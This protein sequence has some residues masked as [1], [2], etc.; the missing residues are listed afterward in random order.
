[1]GIYA[2]LHVHTT[3]SDGQLTL[4]ELPDVAAE[5]ELSVVGVTD[6]DRLHP[7][8]DGPV[9][10]RDGVT[11]VR[12]IELRVQA[13]SQ[14]V[15]LLGYGVEQTDPLQTR[16]EALQQNRI[17]RTR[18]ILERVE[19]R[20]EIRLDVALT[21]GV[22]RPHV[23]R[24]LEAHDGV[25][26]D[27][28]EAFQTLIGPDCPCYVAREIPDFETAL[29]LL[30]ESCGLVSL[31]HPLRYPDPES[32]LELASDLDAVER[33]YPYEEPVDSSPVE[34]TVET[35]ALLV[36]GGSDAHDATLGR[37]GLDEAAWDQLAAVLKDS[38]KPE[39]SG[40][41]SPNSRI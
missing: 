34:D 32:A 25:D 27:G 38:P 33:Y 16:L 36:T 6:H 30:R 2:D 9:E 39:G 23:A 13:D 24:A 37:A 5:L 3:V 19:D 18:Q 17:E 28:N 10:S 4:E 29:E 1:M 26:I 15:D 11:L 20:L 21:E 12:G 22:G 41:S 35:D 14:R 8:F 31:A 7:G 40:N